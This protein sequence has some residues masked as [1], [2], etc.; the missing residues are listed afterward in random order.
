MSQVQP[1][2]NASI[3]GFALSIPVICLTLHI[4]ESVVARKLDVF[5]ESALP[6]QP[7]LLVKLTQNKLEM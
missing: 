3:H 5:L 7:R 2:G 1:G 6:A 4:T